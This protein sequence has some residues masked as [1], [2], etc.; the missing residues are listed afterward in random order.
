MTIYPVGRILR[1]LRC[2]TGLSIKE[3]T[4]IL[5]HDYEHKISPSTLYGYE[6]GRLNVSADLLMMLCEI[7]H[8]TDILSAFTSHSAASKQRSNHAFSAN[9]YA[10]EQTI[11]SNVTGSASPLYHSDSACYTKQSTCR[12]A[13]PA[14]SSSSSGNSVLADWH[15]S[16]YERDF[17]QKLRKVDPFDQSMLM[18][19]LDY[20]CLRED[21][22]KQKSGPASL[23]QVADKPDEEH[24]Q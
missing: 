22:Q 19:V 6:S 14:C 11:G 15:L 4:S 16:F 5:E 23:R 18:A 8:C 1:D 3:V 9:A 21:L 13:K 24:N 10:S 2:K 17:I 7:Y 20:A 12:A